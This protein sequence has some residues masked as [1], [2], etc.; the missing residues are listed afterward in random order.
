MKIIKHQKKFNN[1]TCQHCG[2]IY[3]PNWRD[4]YGRYF[5]NGCFVECPICAVKHTLDFKKDLKEG[6]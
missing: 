1:I 6:K 3:K 4:V 2:T 5:E